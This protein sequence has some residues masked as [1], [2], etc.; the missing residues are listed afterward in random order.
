MIILASQ[1]P[2]RRELIKKITTDFTVIPSN[3]DESIIHTEPHALP[4]ELSKLKAYS[5][6][7]LYPNDTVL[8]CDTVVILN[9]ELMGKPK[10]KEQAKEMLRKLS[11]KKHV[12]ISGYTFI[13]KDR[14]ITRTVRT[15]VYF[16]NLSEET[17]NAYVESGSPMDK[18]GAYGIQDKD[19]DLVNHIEGS[20]YNVIGLP[21]E[22]IKAHCF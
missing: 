2:R 17:I 22:D 9:N 3:I 15:Y 20:L 5:I 4:A 11:G 8:A 10:T 13:N 7:S 18:A 6:F 19:F 1:S 14:E 21:V 16:N 12:V